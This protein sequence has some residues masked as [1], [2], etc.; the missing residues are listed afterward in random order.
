M[1]EH[2]ATIRDYLYEPPGPRARKRTRIATAI[3][4]FALAILL[5]GILRRFY[6]TGQLDAR[7]WSIFARY[8][9]WRFLG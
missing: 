6:E 3:A 2:R 4:L 7:Y 5:V 8:T 9:T 1:K